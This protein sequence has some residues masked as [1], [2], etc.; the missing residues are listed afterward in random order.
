MDKKTLQE[1]EAMCNKPRTTGNTTLKLLDLI[2]RKGT[3]NL[4]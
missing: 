4:A 3:A 1:F 2:E